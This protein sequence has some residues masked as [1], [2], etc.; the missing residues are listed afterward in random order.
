MYTNNIVTLKVFAATLQRKSHLCIPFLGI[1]RPQSQFPHFSCVCE[2]IIYS[3]DQ[4]TYF[5]AAE[6]ADRPWEYIKRSH[7]HKGGNFFS[8]NI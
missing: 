7:T 5:P 3:Q 4:S 6:K 8:G 2:H 1:A